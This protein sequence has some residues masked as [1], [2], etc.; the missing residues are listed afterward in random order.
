MKTLKDIKEE[1]KQIPDEIL[2]KCGF[3][4]GENCED[5]ISVIY[6]DDNYAE[7]F[8]KYPQLG[9]FDNLI[10]NIKK[11]QEKI[12][13]KNWEAYAELFEQDVISNESLPKL[14]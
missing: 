12:E 2:E 10:Q 3:G 14:S 4:I 8:A 9:V 1:L 11:A 13:G 5:T 7:I 6:Y